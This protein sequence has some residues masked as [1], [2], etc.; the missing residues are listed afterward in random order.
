MY[1]IVRFYKTERE[2]KKELLVV[3]G[4]VGFNVNLYYIHEVE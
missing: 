4:C 3:M 1:Q 2:I